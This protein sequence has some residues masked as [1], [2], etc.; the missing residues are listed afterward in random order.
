MKRA[1]IHL[2]IIAVSMLASAYIAAEANNDGRAFDSATPA[3]ASSLTLL[4]ITPEG[5]DVPAGRQIV[6]QFDRTVVPVGRMERSADEI[7]I[8]ITPALQCEWRWI[9]TSALACQLTEK[10]ALRP[11]TE[12]HV[13]VNPGL[14]TDDGVVMTVPVTHWFVTERPKVTRTYFEEW[15]APGW[16]RIQV[17][18]NQAVTRASVKQHLKLQT[19]F[20][21][22]NDY[23]IDVKPSEHDREPVLYA[24]FPGEPYALWN[25]AY[26]SRTLDDRKTEVRGEEARRI[27][28]V[29]PQEELP[30]DS[31]VRLQIEP[32]LVSALGPESGHE[33][34]TAVEFR[35]YPEFRFLGVQCMLASTETS[36][37]LDPEYRSGDELPD[38]IDQCLPTESVALVF[39]APV[40]NEEIKAHLRFTPDLAGGRTDYDPWANRY[41]YSRLRYPH[42]KDQTYSVYLPELLKAFQRYEITSDA[43][44][45]HDEFNRPLPAPVNMAFMTSHRPPRLVLNHKKAVLE[46]QVD[47]DVP[48][49]ITNLDVLKVPHRTI[50]T[51]GETSHLD[52]QQDVEKAEDISFAMRLGVRDMLG[53]RSGVVTGHLDSEPRTKYYDEDSFR[54]FAQVTPFQVHVKLGHFNS[55]VWVTD[56]ATGKPVKG[57]TLAVY[58]D[59]YSLNKAA[60]G[61]AAESEPALGETTPAE[62]L[63]LANRLENLIA[64]ISR[65][66]TH[67]APKGTLATATTDGDGIASLPGVETLSPDLKLLQYG[68]RDDQARLFIRVD[69]DEDFALLPLD[70]NFITRSG[71]AGS[72]NRVK[73][74]HL[75]AWGTT[76]QGVYKAGDTIQ[77]KFYVRNQSNRHWVAPPAGDYSLKV[78]DPKG[79]IVEEIETLTLSEF[80]AYAGEIKLSDRAAV[81]WYRFQLQYFGAQHQTLEALHVLVSDF[82]PSPF[83]VTTDL[84]GTQFEPG[85]TLEA[86]TLAKLHAGG[87]YTQAETRT[88]A[89]LYQQPFRSEH[90]LAKQFTFEPY[91]YNEREVML[92]QSTDTGDDQGSVTTRFTLQDQNIYY[93]RIAVE[94]AVRDDRGKFVAAQAGARYYG[95]DRYVG[96]RNTAWT[97]E[98]DKPAAVEYLVVDRDGAPVAGTPVRINIEREQVKASRVK[99]AGNAYLTQYINEWVNAGSCEGVSTPEALTCSFTPEEPGSYRFT[100]VISDTKQR[101]HRSQIGAWVIG[102][103]QVY[104]QEP[105]DYS[106]Q[107]IPEETQYRVGDTARFLVKNPFPGARALITVE[108]YGVLKHWVEILDESTTIIEVPI[109]ADYLHGFYLSVL[110]NSPR[111][112]KPLGDD[113]VDL[114]KPT[115]RLGYLEVPVKDVYKEIDVQIN[116]DRDVYKPREKVKAHIHAAPRQDAG[117]EPLEIAAVVIDEAVFDLNG[118]GR[119]YYDPYQGFNRLDNLDLNNYSLLTRLVGRQKFEKKGANPGGDGDA[120]GPTLRNLFKFVSY[121]NPSILPDKN[122]N[123]NIEFEL[124]DNLTGWRIFALAVTPG[125]RMG[126][127]DTGIKVNKPTELRPVM[128][129]QVIEGDSFVAGFSVM[130]RTENPRTVTV[131]INATGALDPASA[132]RKTV[133]LTLEPYKRQ[134]VWLPVVTKGPGEIGFLATA[135]DVLDGDALEHHVVVNKRRSSVTAANYGTTTQPE[136][137]DNITFP[138]NI[139]PD[140][141]GISVVTSPSVIGNIDGAFNYIR[142]YP[143]ACWEQQLTKAVMASHYNN[144]RAYLPDDLSWE[145][146]DAL[147]QSLLD[148]A[149]SFQAPNG[150][151]TYWIPENRYVS[152]YLSAYTALAFNWLRNSGYT[153]PEAVERKLHDYLADMLRHDVMPTFFSEGMASSVRAVA[154]A[155]LAER[156]S[157]GL[158]E[159]TRHESHLPEMDLFGKAH[160]LQAASFIDGARPIAI[161]TAKQI[162]S[163]ASQSGG[164][165]QFNEPWDDSYSYIL[166]TPLR[167]NCAILSALM[168]ITTDAETLALVGDIPF[169]QVR[170]IT[171]ARGN[172]DHWENTQENVFCMNALTDYARVYENEKPDMTVKAYLGDKAIGETRYTDLRDTAVTFDDPATKV[173]P[174]LKTEVKLTKNGPG[175]LYYS[176]RMR[177]APTADNA[178]RINSGIEIRREYSVERDGKWTLLTSPMQIGRGELIR[179]DLFVSL[180]TLRHFVVVDDPVPGGLEP[181]NRDLATASLVDAD[182]GEFK[183]ADGSFWFHYSD[184][185]YYGVY[186]YSFYHK[187]LRH[188]AARFYADYLPAG[189]YHLSYTAQ[190]IAAGEFSVMPVHAEEMYDPDVFGKGLPAVLKV[191][192][193]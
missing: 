168:R 80:G 186:G 20:P 130:N 185:S 85:D 45:I 34:R 41:S 183:A 35:T 44:G 65:P 106:L 118:D 145:N 153:V 176:T 64:N 23:R 83:R 140:V 193:E 25:P 11:A 67:P 126:L 178:Q 39:S 120:G 82:T 119:N 87:P 63:S 90:A 95:R 49:Y 133:Q 172:R 169:K 156:G 70:D 180:P 81:G 89:R 60:Q 57:A 13:R 42:R 105:D 142:D 160:F 177:Y 159:L 138:E 171:Q 190:A 12:Y 19:A 10:N 97:Y 165:F 92:H 54:F 170:A 151:M 111:V 66:E 98:E 79:E 1:F 121:W 4:R 18:F 58:V 107:I 149:A 9:N 116:T 139:Y 24:P 162:L 128:P 62:N 86:V 115:F 96:L 75:H 76:A 167:S 124:P 22:L 158:S 38:D 148:H 173:S 164:K 187:E 73:D 184:W 93:G 29:E 161:K 131:E 91:P 33:S 26:A 36:R 17:T 132:D 192:T 122:G 179:V 104:W 46:K 147:P 52:D 152:P 112:E 40:I 113:N 48:V 14:R 155:A 77:Y 188:D 141:G 129:N 100:A 27:W 6:F 30:L 137:S 109:E 16:P 163:Y 88:T 125:D 114:G 7:P 191:S 72:S 103:G 5:P 144:L 102:K 56:L 117:G 31:D 134:T 68:W 99:G 150:G 74:G 59:N 174:G 135:G 146:S 71:G 28:V 182:K 78:T 108:R 69:K 61:F 2:Y 84:N 166:A 21:S 51:D 189:N 127:G 50:T 37:I 175:R 43:T 55:L 3:T 154:L 8:E 53:R 157:I 123:A 143:Y 32:G 94:G 110:V 47:T 181:V 101:Q 15:R 136:V